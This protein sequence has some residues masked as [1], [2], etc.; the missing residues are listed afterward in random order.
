MD[1]STSQEEREEQIELFNQQS[2][3]PDAP[4]VF[5]LSTRAGGLGIN[6]VGADSIIF[7][8]SDWNPQVDIQAMDRVHRIG[9]TR[10]VL[11]FRLVTQNSVEQKMMMT[12]KSKRKLESMVI[13]QGHYK[14]DNSAKKVNT[15]HERLTKALD[16]L[17]ITNVRIADDDE[18]LVSDEELNHLLDRSDEAMKREQGWTHGKGASN[19]AQVMGLANESN[20]DDNIKMDDLDNQSAQ[21]SSNLP[22]NVASAEPS[23]AVSESA[24]SHK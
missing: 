17:D 6:L 23:R 11:I 19:V 9:Q 22:S 14:Q 21:E 18:K 5:L 2:D 12:A 1:G 10:P 20:S 7:Y 3:D 24:E 13:T 4:K 8:D 16:E 15:T